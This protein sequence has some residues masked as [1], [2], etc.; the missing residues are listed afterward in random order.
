MFQSVPRRQGTSADY[1]PLPL[2]LAS[3][4][5]FEHAGQPFEMVSSGILATWRALRPDSNPAIAKHLAVQGFDQAALPVVRDFD[6]GLTGPQIDSS[7]TATLQ[8]SN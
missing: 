8:L 3:A 7:Y 1:A 4:L 2:A 6:Y 5:Q